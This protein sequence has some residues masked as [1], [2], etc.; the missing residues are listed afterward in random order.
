MTDWRRLGG[1]NVAC[2][3]NNAWL[4]RDTTQKSR[5]LGKCTKMTTLFASALP[6]V[7]ATALPHPTLLVLEKA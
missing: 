5:R 1:E 7:P 6:V 4:H 3:L 2:L